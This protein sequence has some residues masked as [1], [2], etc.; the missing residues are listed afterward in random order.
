M[1][2]IVLAGFLFSVACGPAADLAPQD[3]DPPVDPSAAAV[4]AEPDTQRSASVTATATAAA[5]V[6]QPL[7]GTDC[8]TV[9]PLKDGAYELSDV[10]QLQAIDTS[11][12]SYFS[13][14]V[15]V[16]FTV[17]LV[18]S[19]QRYLFELKNVVAV[20]SA[21][22]QY[23]TTQT[24]R[25]AGLQSAGRIE[26]RAG[27][28]CVYPALKTASALTLQQDCLFPALESVS[29]LTLDGVAAVTG[30]PKLQR[31]GSVSVS[32]SGALDIKGFKALAQVDQLALKVPTSKITGS[33]PA[34][35]TVEQLS[36]SDADLTGFSLPKLTAVTRSLSQVRCRELSRPFKVLQT[37]GHWAVTASA[38]SQKLAGP[39]TLI[40]LGSLD[41]DLGTNRL[42]LSGFSGLK[43]VSGGIAAR[44]SG[45]LRVSGFGEL[46]SL[47]AMLIVAST[48]G[49]EGFNK[50]AEIGGPL[51]IR[52]LQDSVY[53]DDRFTA[54]R[55]LTDIMGAVE[56]S[57]DDPESAAF[58]LLKSVG[59]DLSFRELERPARAA[60]VFPLLETVAGSL[61]VE[62]Q[63]ASFAALKRVDKTLKILDV[64]GSLS[65]KR[66]DGFRK[67]TVVGGDLV[68]DKNAELRDAQRIL[69][70]L[71]GFAGT[72]RLE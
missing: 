23:R 49:M 45:N 43:T 10:S 27:G 72:V 69:D 58:P 37:A 36:I 57:L 16:A 50:L 11:G 44:G 19:S 46:T 7:L 48:L 60:N 3:T 62:N 4:A 47:G 21:I 17:P 61:T 38:S 67:L 8:G 53:T 34:L 13:G 24:V 41:V 52:T 20:S 32:G 12:C 71:V 31:A 68:I 54:F 55:A 35:Q 25:F 70:R 66:I 9:V 33:F 42:E 22:T 2:N 26:V 14:D 5:T 56:L 28:T 18:P 59:G 6:L 63:A 64:P 1:K 29:S 65:G 39:A 40:T 15:R 30:F 51:T